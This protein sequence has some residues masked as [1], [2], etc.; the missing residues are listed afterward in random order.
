VTLAIKESARRSVAAPDGEAACTASDHMKAQASLEFMASAFLVLLL[1]GI[2]VWM[3]G[4]SMAEAGA[5]RSSMEANRVCAQVSSTLSSLASSG[6][7]TSYRFSLPSKVN[8]ENY[9]I[10]VVSARNTVK[11][12]FANRAGVGCGLPSM[13]ITNSTGASFF[14]LARNATATSSN[15]VVRVA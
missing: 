2:A 14:A 8:G 15:G 7:A 1:F 12:D 6:G 4:T 10:Y 9:T 3:Y 11:V 5:L 13:N